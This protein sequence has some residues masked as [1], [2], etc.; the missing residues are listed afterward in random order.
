MKYPTFLLRKAMHSHKQFVESYFPSKGTECARLLAYDVELVDWDSGVPAS[1]AI[2]R[3]KSAFS[4]NRG[5]HE[6]PSQITRLTEEGSVGVAEGYARRAKK[7]GGTWTG[8]SAIPST[9][10]EAK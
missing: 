4:R 7:D 6:F 2:T 1:G 3:G 10:R 5:R 9:S 8:T